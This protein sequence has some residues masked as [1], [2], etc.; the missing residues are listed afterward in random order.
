MNDWDRAV[1]TLAES[2]GMTVAQ[3]QDNM[4]MDE[5]MGWLKFHQMRNEDYEKASGKGKE[6]PL[7]VSTM[8]QDQLREL[9]G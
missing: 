8:S 3:L 6:E 7:D 5:F 2:L 9:F 1:Y 4:T